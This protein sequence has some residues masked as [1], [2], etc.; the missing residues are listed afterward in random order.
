MTSKPEDKRLVTE[1]DARTLPAP[2]EKSW[3]FYDGADPKKRVAGFGIRITASGARAFV[4]NYRFQGQ[5][6]RI[7]IGKYPDWKVADAREK[8]KE[9]GK[10]I[11]NGHDPLAK[12][13]EAR[14]APTVAKLCDR[15]LE[16]AKH[17]KRASSL[18]EDEA[19]IRQWIRPELGST[20]VAKVEI[21]DIEA[22][23]R[24]ISAK[25]LIR[26]N[27]VRALLSKMFTLASTQW[28]KEFNLDHNPAKGSRRNA[29]QG[30]VAQELAPLDLALDELAL[31][32]GQKGMFVSGSHGQILPG[33]IV[34]A[35]VVSLST[36]PR[37]GSRLTLAPLSFISSGQQPPSR[38]G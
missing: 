18:A 23:H 35:V 16:W 34:S 1:T 14:E 5:E 20:K 32:C 29:E 13:I 38:T 9:L 2:A 31:E 25:T 33:A 21:D 15:F 4:L 28:R 12:R 30:R 26:A 11:D 37:A 8:A 19:M 6:R 3:I 22:L 24:K 10:E 27:R 17:E 7:T 36:S